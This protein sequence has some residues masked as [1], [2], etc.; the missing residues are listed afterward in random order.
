MIAYILSEGST[1]GIIQSIMGE[2]IGYLGINTVPLSLR[3]KSITFR[4]RL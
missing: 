3:K 1:S 2:F 4:E